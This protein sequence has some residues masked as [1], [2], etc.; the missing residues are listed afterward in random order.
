MPDARFF[1]DTNVLLYSN[2]RKNPE[3][4]LKASTWLK[5][6][7]EHGAVVINLQVLNEC[8]DVLLRKSGLKNRSKSSRR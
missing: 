5:V 8:T 7:T 6:L 4:T 2:D 1:V 3:K